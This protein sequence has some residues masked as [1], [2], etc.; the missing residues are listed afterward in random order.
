MSVRKF[1]AGGIAVAGRYGAVVAGAGALVAAL[2]VPSAPAA[3]A[4]GVDAQC[5]GAVTSTYSPGITN[6]PQTVTFHVTG[7]LGPCA[8][9]GDPHL[10]SGTFTASGT[11]TFSC[12]SVTT[13]FQEEIHWNDGKESDIA[14]TMAIGVNPLGEDVY[15]ANGKVVSDGDS[16]EEF[17]GDTYLSTGPVLTLNPLACAGSGVTSQSGTIDIT[18]TNP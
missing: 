14:G 4:A 16:H 5:T 13:G 10:S 1:F 12:T 7:L 8:S 15:V 9:T 18:I 17:I 6:T 11:G 3:Y 2:L